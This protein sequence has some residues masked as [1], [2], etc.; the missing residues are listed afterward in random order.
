MPDYKSTLNLPKTD[1]AMKAN[2]A[3]AEPQTVKRWQDERLYDAVQEARA[4]AP[5]FSFHDGPPYANG[6]IHLGHLLNKVLKDI[7]VR[8]RLMDGMRVPYVPGWDCHGLPIE[9]KVVT[10][11]NEKGK[12]QKVLELP[13]DQRRMVIRR[14]CQ[15]YAEKFVKLQ[16]GQMQRL[17][18]LADYANPYLT[19]KPAFEGAVLEDFAELVEQG[20]ERV[21]GVEDVVD[22]QDIVA[23]QVG[24][25]IQPEFEFP[26]SR[27]GAPIA[28]R[29]D[30]AHLH[31][32]FESADQIGDED[33]AA[34]QHADDDQ[35][36]LA[37]RAADLA[38]KPVDA[39]G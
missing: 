38:R 35:R 24:Q 15:A 12:L 1:F 9:H 33:D 18:T 25:Q 3:Q 2:L 6:S 7:V 17:L 8:A 4:G 22:E 11:M 28:A 36:P 30:H 32:P 5:M 34:G 37:N 20:L 27:G 19:M 31:G 26:G 10:E 39:G 16:A 23:G 21:A 13:D 29:P 14:E